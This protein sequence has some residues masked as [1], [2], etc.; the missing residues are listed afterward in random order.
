MQKANYIPKTQKSNFYKDNQENQIQTH[1][2]SHTSP[3]QQELP[4]I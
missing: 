1:L 4:A 3:I 2:K